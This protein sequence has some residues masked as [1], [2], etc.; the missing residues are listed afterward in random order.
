MPIGQVEWTK[1]SIFFELLVH[2]LP[3]PRD[4]SGLNEILESV[5]LESYRLAK[6][7]ELSIVL[8]NKDGETSTKQPG[9]ARPFEPEM[10]SL[11]VIIA[12][13]NDIFGNIDWNDKDNVAR[14]IKELPEMVAKDERIINA[15][16]NSDKENIKIE[17]EN[18][19][20]DVIRSIMKDN[21]ELFL[22][23]TSN[24]QFK[25]WLSDSV[26]NEIMKKQKSYEDKKNSFK[27][28]AEDDQNFGLDSD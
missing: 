4:D 14:Q 16:K 13:F 19:L 7:N 22:Q 27:L 8:E 25:K 12:N 5:D 26:F 3:T 11:D 18:V 24:F 10:E 28:A 23:F 2:R 17:Y 1:K 6:Q 21:M 9:T 20:A 15:I